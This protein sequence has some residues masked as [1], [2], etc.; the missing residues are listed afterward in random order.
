MYVGTCFVWTPSGYLPKSGIAGSY[1]SSRGNFLRNHPTRPQQSHL[2]VRVLSCLLDWSPDSGLC[3]SL[4]AMLFICSFLHLLTGRPAEV[5]VSDPWM[6]GV[7]IFGDW[8]Q[9]FTALMLIAES[10]TICPQSLWKAPSPYGV[11]ECIIDSHHWR[12]S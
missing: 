5:M 11:G 8:E 9:L 1:D 10:V 3:V 6:A 7:S 2:R 4:T 12:H